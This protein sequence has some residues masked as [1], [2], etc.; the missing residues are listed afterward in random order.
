MIG[1]GW[2]EYPFGKVKVGPYFHA[3]QNIN[4]RWTSDSNMK[5]G[6]IK[7]LENS[8]GAYLHEFGK[9]KI[10]YAGH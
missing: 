9:G 1:S 5:N 2:V 6:I 8:L 10:S 4:S 7:L 3:M